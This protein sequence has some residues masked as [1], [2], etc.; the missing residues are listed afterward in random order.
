MMKTAKKSVLI[1][2]LG[3][4]GKFAALKYM[5]LGCEVMVVDRSEE[6]VN[7]MAPFVTSAQIADA[8]KPDVLKAI[9]VQ[10]FDICLVAIGDNFQSSLEI[11]SQLKECGAKYVISK[12]IREIQEKFLLRNG[13]DEVVYPDKGMAERL[14]I[15]TTASNVLDFF[16]IT[17]SVSIY[18]IAVPKSWIGKSVVELDVR[19]RF[20][21]SVVATKCE[22]DVA[23]PNAQHI[24]KESESIIVIGDKDDIMKIS[25]T[26]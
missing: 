1:V 13:A 16:N 4:F 2:G 12:A 17:E 21:I 7:E 18:E 25:K 11:T 20:N 5:E 15:R 23:I 3:S 9:G 6:S 22:E 24:F 10:D 14:A 26:K 19:R 8:T